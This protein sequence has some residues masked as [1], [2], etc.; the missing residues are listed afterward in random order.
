M[1][2]LSCEVGRQGCTNFT[3]VAQKKK[4]KTQKTS[5][6]MW[7]IHAKALM[8]I[9]AV[10]KTSSPDVAGVDSWAWAFYVTTQTNQQ[11]SC[12]LNSDQKWRF[13]TRDVIESS[14]F[15]VGSLRFMTMRWI[16]P[17]RPPAEI[18]WV[19]GQAWRSEVHVDV[20]R[21]I[22]QPCLLGKLSCTIRLLPQTNRLRKG[23]W[24]TW[25]LLFKSINLYVFGLMV[26]ACQICDSR[27]R[28]H[29]VISESERLKL[30]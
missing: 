13:R 10:P 27:Y 26:I 19:W 5:G 28:F 17:R 3:F 29:D 14:E 22:N 1:S 7:I 9:K 30:C 6:Q 20:I 11:P 2:R 21:L 25:H 4:K 12:K 18:R 23:W 16:I 8:C 24:Q 15:R